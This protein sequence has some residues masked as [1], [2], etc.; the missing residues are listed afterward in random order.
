MVSVLR[1]RERTAPVRG[2]QL[3]KERKESPLQQAD[4]GFS[5]LFFAF[6]PTTEYI[7]C[8]SLFSAKTEK[9]GGVKT[10]HG[11]E[12]ENKNIFF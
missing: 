8:A 4:S 11:D 9:R 5:L 6:G 2:I 7:Q 12:H 3:G 10:K 1:L